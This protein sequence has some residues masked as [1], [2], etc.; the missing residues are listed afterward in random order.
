[1]R[2]II[3]H[4]HLFKNAGTSLDAAFKE[5]L[6]VDE[7]VTSEFPGN[8]S[9]NRKMVQEWIVSNPKA[10]CFSSHTAVLPPPNIKGIDILPV[11][12]VRHPIDRIASAYA[13]ERK[14]DGSS[15]GSVLAR[16]TDFKGYV[17]TRLALLH[18]RQCR[19]F[20]AQKLSA[21]FEQGDEKSRAFR[22]LDALPF[23]GLVED[24]QGSLK[25]LNAMAI[26]REYT[27]TPLSIVRKNVSRASSGTL[28]DKIDQIRE[29]LGDE[30]YSRLIDCN[31]I[32]LEIFEYLKKNI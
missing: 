30:L 3:F 24:F 13:F 26:D 10:K 15:F 7:W 27:D 5:N 14:Q 31:S 17:E 23:V 4:Y 25:T 8:P 18:D 9:L 2:K 21:M 29:Q 1:M 20:H 28:E 6:A 12:F 19:D 11:I 32:D 16:N 22:A